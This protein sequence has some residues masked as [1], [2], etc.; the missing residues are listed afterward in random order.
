MPI[1]LEII[2]RSVLSFLVLLVVCRLT[3]KSFKIVLPVAL[4]VIAAVFS[5][6]RSIRMIDSLVALVTW[7]ALIVIYEFVAIKSKQAQTVLNGKPTV[8]IEDGNIIGK[9]LL[10]VRMTANELLGHLREK[11]AFKLADVEFAVLETDGQMSVMKKSDVQPVT[12]KTAG[13]AVQLE[14]APKVVIE[15]GVVTYN[16][17][18]ENGYSEGRLLSEIQKQGARSDDD[19]FLAQLDSSD[20]VYVDLKND[21]FKKTPDYPTNKSKLLLL[22]S[23]KKLESD[24]EGYALQTENSQAKASY[25]EG[26]RNLQRVIAQVQPQLKREADYGSN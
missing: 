11:D 6:D 1:Y 14:K 21:V 7:T 13:I 16:T 23:L 8:L 3:G 4:A 9:N 20:N 24:L 25:Q 17:L 10:K 26:A 12:P 19:V 15:D 2:F 22:G 5:F 18:L